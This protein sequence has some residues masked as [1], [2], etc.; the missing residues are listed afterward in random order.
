MQKGCEVR[1]FRS[2]Q[3]YLFV[4]AEYYTFTPYNSEIAFAA[5]SS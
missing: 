5:P 3:P 1:V 4:I 2:S